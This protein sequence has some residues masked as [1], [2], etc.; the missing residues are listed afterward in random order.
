MIT[1][2]NTSSCL[3]LSE[4]G[5]GRGSAAGP[6]L[7]QDQR[8]PKT[9]QITKAANNISPQTTAFSTHPP[10]HKSSE[11]LLSLHTSRAALL[12][13]LLK[14]AHRISRVTMLSIVLR[15]LCFPHHNNLLSAF[16]PSSCLCPHTA[17]ATGGEWILCAKA[18]HANRQQPSV[19]H[20]TK[21]QHK[22]LLVLRL[23]LWGRE[24]HPQ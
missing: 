9:L 13:H 24:L 10:T 17:V 18:L 15:I 12:V 14:N 11:T 7:T 22:R 4:Q 5:M 23:V 21:P 16:L 20:S 19:A 8:R 6:R 3:A 2:T 1:A